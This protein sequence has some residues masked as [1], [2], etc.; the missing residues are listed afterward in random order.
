MMLS[1]LI[2]LKHRLSVLENSRVV[3]SWSR[4]QRTG[5]PAGSAALSPSALALGASVDLLRSGEREARQHKGI[6]CPLGP[7]AGVWLMV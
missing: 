7:N 2:A 1:G 5:E 6:S 3:Q 4:K